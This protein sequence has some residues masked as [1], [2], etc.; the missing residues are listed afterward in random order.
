MLKFVIAKT[1]HIGWGVGGKKKEGEIWIL[2]KYMYM[3]VSVFR[4]DRCMYG[5]QVGGG[6]GQI[7]VIW[8][9]KYRPEATT[10]QY[11]VNNSEKKIVMGEWEWLCFWWK[12]DN[13]I[14]IKRLYQDFL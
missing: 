11:W 13:V 8:D 1:K 12:Q 3:Y 10:K 9:S 2:R 7:G 4:E 5:I 6:T 14:L